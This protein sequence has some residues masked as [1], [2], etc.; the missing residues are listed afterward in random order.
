MVALYYI[1]IIY[2]VIEISFY[3]DIVYRVKKKKKKY[4]IPTVFVTKH[5]DRP[6]FYCYTRRRG[7]M[8]KYPS[9]I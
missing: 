9:I 1:T 3:K 6:V 2:R 8:F 7:N 5:F 4:A